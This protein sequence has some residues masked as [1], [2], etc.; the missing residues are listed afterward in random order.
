[1]AHVAALTSFFF[2]VSLL[3]LL[4]RRS[5]QSQLRHGPSPRGGNYILC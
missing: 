1:M 5:F 3:F 4:F 2:I